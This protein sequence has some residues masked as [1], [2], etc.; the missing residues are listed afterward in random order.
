[1]ANFAPSNL[2]DAQAN[3]INKF[4]SGEMRY[5]TP[6]AWLS[7][8][9]SQAIAT[10]DYKTLRTREDRSLLLN[11]FT[12]KKRTLT[13]GRT[14]NPTGVSGDTAVLVPVFGV[15]ADTT[16]ISIKQMDKNMRTFQEALNNNVLNSVINM[17]EG[18]DSEAQ[19]FIFNNRS[20]VNNAL[21]AEGVFNVANDVYE[22][23]TTNTSRAVQITQTVMDINKYQ[24]VALDIY[25]DSIS[26]NAF[27]FA[28][29]Q[30]SGNSTNLEYQFTIGDVRFIHAPE[31]NQP[32]NALG[33][34]KG[35]WVT[36]ERG[37]AVALDWIPRQNREGIAPM[38]IGG[39]GEYSSLLN[40]IDGLSYAS[41][42][43]WER[44]DLVAQ[45]GQTQDVRETL[46]ISIDRAFEHAPLTNPNE[47]PL[48]AFGI[49]DTP[50]MS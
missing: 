39:E 34:T 12:R 41:F 1:M 23:A 49:K 17:I 32:A 16:H 6:A 20:G 19:S 35:F 46:E 22:I 28:R 50:A 30:G 36:C 18:L 5:R 3:L 8:I 26:F 44:A 4:Q 27:N 29:A 2:L 21:F 43:V 10:P 33:Y 31:F 25:C 15:R 48:M 47:T 9:E 11:F 42:K 24:G 37:M 14:A 40:P 13:T 7:L 45:N 38:A